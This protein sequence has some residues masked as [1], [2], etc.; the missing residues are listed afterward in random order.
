MLK[1]QDVS[2]CDYDALIEYINEIDEHDEGITD[3]YHLLKVDM[4]LFNIIRPVSIDIEFLIDD[5]EPNYILGNA[6]TDFNDKTLT[7]DLGQLSYEIRPSMRG[8]GLGKEVLKL[9]IDKAYRN[10]RE[11]IYAS[12]HLNN[13]GS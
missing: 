3:L 13:E 9:L 2:K 5:E 1:L 10:N 11:F 7:N 4:T 8:K 12:C 6:T